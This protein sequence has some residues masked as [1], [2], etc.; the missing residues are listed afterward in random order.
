MVRWFAGWWSLGLSHFLG[1]DHFDGKQ[2]VWAFLGS[3]L[4]WSRWSGGSWLWDSVARPLASRV[5]GEALEHGKL[6]ARAAAAT[7]LP[8]N[9]AAT[10]S[11]EQKSAFCSRGVPA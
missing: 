9:S 1:L 4:G 11:L 5:R 7:G 8:G 6:G 2:K 10:A 3:S